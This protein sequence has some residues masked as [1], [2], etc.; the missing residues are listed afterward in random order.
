LSRFIIILVVPVAVLL[1]MTPISGRAGMPSVLPSDLDVRWEQSADARLRLE[2]ISFFLASFVASVV[3]VKY[4][5]N[6]LAGSIQSLPRIDFLRA[7]AVVVLWGLIFS[8]VLTM[9]SGA[10]ELL[11][12]G[13]WKQNGFTYE[14]TKGSESS[15]AST[16]MESDNP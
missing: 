2:S 10:R 4:L 1:L 3:A 7:L 6:S 11:T 15:T 9:I 8:L 16:A 5:W 14:L 13:A 12:P